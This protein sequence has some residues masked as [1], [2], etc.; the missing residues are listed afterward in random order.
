[1]RPVHGLSGSL[2][3]DPDDTTAGHQVQHLIEQLQ[4]SRKQTVATFI[5]LSGTTT[6][7]RMFKLDA[8]EMIM[9][10]SSDADIWLDDEGVSRFH[11]KVVRE[12]EQIRLVDLNSRNGTFCNGE[13]V[14]SRLLRD[15]DKI[16]VGTTTILKFSFQ[17]TLDEALQRNLY[18]SAT[19]DALTGVY[20]KRFFLESLR[21]QFAF[22]QR[23][24]Q[25]LSL[26]MLDLDYFKL[27]NDTYGHLAGDRVLAEVSATINDAIRAEDIFARFGG[28]EFSLLLLDVPEDSARLVAERIRQMIEELAIRFE[29]QTLKVTASI[30]VATLKE[31]RYP[32]PESLIAAADRYLYRAKELGR[33]LVVARSLSEEDPKGPPTA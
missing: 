28:E 18:E 6:V 15:G 11:A 27:V 5:I 30:G 3:A 29:A 23:N 10:R 16:Q 4:S 17:D 31:R 13:R 14:V 24:G 2:V 25:P 8:K 32:D 7:G 33:N 20:N 22:C 26:V 21:K 19:K 12:G 1:M 9:G